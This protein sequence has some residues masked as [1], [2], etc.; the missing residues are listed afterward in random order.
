MYKG[1]EPNRVAAKER[2]EGRYATERPCKWGHADFRYTK[3]GV[4]CSCSVGRD[5][6]RDPNLDPT[7]V[8]ARY[9][10]IAKENGNTRFMSP[11]PCPNG[12]HAERGTSDGK[13]VECVGKRHRRY[14]ERPEIAEVQK[15]R[16]AVWREENREHVL[17][18]KRRWYEE[19]KDYA[20]QLS[21]EWWADNKDKH[22][23]YMRIVRKRNPLI[24]RAH[25]KAYG[26]RVKQAT[27][28][29]S[30]MRKIENTYILAPIGYEVDHI[31]PLKAAGA[32]RVQI[33]CGLHVH[34][35]LQY[36][37]KSVNSSKSNFWTET[38]SKDSCAIVPFSWE[39]FL[40]ISEQ[41]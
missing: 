4:C 6:K 34:G 12:H 13:C 9:R 40:V 30:D 20:K 22:R 29:F 14:M 24:Y 18:E 19:N 8:N 3:N 26:K 1:L 35:N 7:K 31:V 5:V 10:K 21:K 41:A 17:A 38:G 33:A 16:Q 2:G 32:D 27:V 25:S 39:H 23:E 36:L 28:P 37:T 11:F 15:A